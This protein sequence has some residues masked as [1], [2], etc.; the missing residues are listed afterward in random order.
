MSQIYAIHFPLKHGLSLSR[1]HPD[2]GRQISFDH[3][4]KIVYRHHLHR[5]T[6]VSDPAILVCLRSSRTFYAAQV[7]P[8]PRSRH[9]VRTASTSSTGRMWNDGGCSALRQR[10]QP[11]G[12]RSC[13]A[14]ATPLD[15]GHGFEVVASGVLR[16]PASDSTNRADVYRHVRDAEGS[17]HVTDPIPATRSG[18]QTSRRRSPRG[19]RMTSRSMREGRGVCRNGRDRA[20]ERPAPR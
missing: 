12:R 3:C 7:A 20:R 14:A 11:Q 13:R 15:V 18:W 1:A 2:C 5:I 19:I 16:L 8:R 10:R 6:A 17:A 9:L 4:H